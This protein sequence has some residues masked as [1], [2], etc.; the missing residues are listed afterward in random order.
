MEIESVLTQRIGLQSYQAQGLAQAPPQRVGDELA[1]ATQAAARDVSTQFAPSPAKETVFGFTL[2]KFG[3]EYAT[4]EPEIDTQEIAKVALQHFQRAQAS[5]FQS[6]ME[7]AQLRAMLAAP[8]ELEAPELDPA[9]AL[10]LAAKAYARTDQ[11]LQRTATQ[12]G[13]LLGVA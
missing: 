6:E 1:P 13:V 11:A 9:P 7:I 12:P 8:A 10:R 3:I 4:E 2:G 5:S